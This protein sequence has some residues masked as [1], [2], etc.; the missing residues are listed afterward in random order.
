MPASQ[1]FGLLTRQHLSTFDSWL[2][3]APNH[4]YFIQLLATEASSTA[5]I[6]A[7][8]ARADKL[9]DPQQLHAYRSA[10]S[11]KDR[12]GIIYGQYENRE[13]AVAAHP[14]QPHRNKKTHPNPPPVSKR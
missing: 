13:A 11:G 10:L 5:E 6:E 7:F 3:S 2:A 4:H 9:L 12:I 8:L 1:R 14:A